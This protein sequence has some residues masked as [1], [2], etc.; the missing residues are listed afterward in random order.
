MDSFTHMRP[1][2]VGDVVVVPLL[3][4]HSLQHGVRTV[5]F[6][7]PVYE[8]QILS[9]AQ[10]VLTQDHWDTPAAVEQMRL[11]PPEP[12]PFVC[13]EQEDGVLVERIVDFSDF[14]V[15]RV[16]I[17]GSQ[18]LNLAPLQDYALVMVV[19]GDL[20]VGDASFGPEQAL[21]MPRGWG[22]ELA[23]VKPAQGLVFLLAL[24]RV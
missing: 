21:L 6:Q 20:A 19:E 9:F 11:A 2:A 4:P 22:G 10:R 17:E 24:P 18:G 3:M 7:T 14:E 16:K 5:E 13:L 8:R 23:P 12:E 15:R 1:L